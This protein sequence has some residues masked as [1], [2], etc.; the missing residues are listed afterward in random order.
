MQRNRKLNIAERARRL[1]QASVLIAH[2]QRGWG[3]WI[4][5]SKLR[6]DA[7]HGRRESKAALAE[8]RERRLGRLVL[9]DIKPLVGSLRD[10]FGDAESFARGNDVDLADAHRLAASQHG[11]AIMGIVQIFEYHHDSAKPRRGNLIKPGRSTLIEQGPEQLDDRLGRGQSQRRLFVVTT[12]WLPLGT[13]ITRWQDAG[14]VG[15]RT[16]HDAL[17]DEIFEVGKLTEGAE[18]TVDDRVGQGTE[19]IEAEVFTA[20][21]RHRAAADHRTPHECTVEVTAAPGP[22]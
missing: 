11:T 1:G 19:A 2:Q 22:R 6:G 4:Q 14:Q 10:F 9:Q 12:R 7:W 17:Q 15:L 8:R 18:A 3:Q 5:I 20:E 21:A 13:V 16:G